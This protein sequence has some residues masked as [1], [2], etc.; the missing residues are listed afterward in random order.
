MLKIIE[1]H[2]LHIAMMTLNSIV[3]RPGQHEDLFKNMSIY[4]RGCLIL[5]LLL[6]LLLLLLLLFNNFNIFVS[7]AARTTRR[8]AQTR[9]SATG[10]LYYYIITLL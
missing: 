2:S 10:H 8:R 6:S 1:I 5:L 3:A 4:L 7:K 9:L